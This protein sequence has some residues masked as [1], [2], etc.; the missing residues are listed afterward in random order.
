MTS[1]TL[2]RLASRRRALAGALLA[3]GALA[4]TG[5]SAQ[6][7]TTA[8]LSSGVLSVSGDNLANTI[9]VSR[10]AAGTVL[11][12][13]GAGTVLGGTPTVAHTSPGQVFPPDRAG[14]VAPRQ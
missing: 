3:A 4:A 6:A 10:D 5:A 1:P 14:N 2:I 13:G 8:S 12:N 9:T 11:V 7:A